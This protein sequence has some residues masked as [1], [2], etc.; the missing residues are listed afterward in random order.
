[1][2]FLVACYLQGPASAV[3]FIFSRNLT[4]L[5]ILCKLNTWSKFSDFSRFIYLNVIAFKNGKT[6]LT[7][8]SVFVVLRIKNQF[9]NSF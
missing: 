2:L 3:E 6:S 7:Q 9:Y 5:K 4:R 8:P 1:M